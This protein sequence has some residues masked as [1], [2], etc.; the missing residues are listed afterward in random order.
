MAALSQA[1]HWSQDLGSFSN[2]RAQLRG[3][4]GVGSERAP[5]ALHAP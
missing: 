4:I 3:C 2:V 5:S 1:K